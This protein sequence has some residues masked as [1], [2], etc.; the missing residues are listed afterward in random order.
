M[1]EISI[2]EAFESARENLNW[3]V[4]GGEETSAKP[5]LLNI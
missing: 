5:C 2:T 3:T 1:T 4:P